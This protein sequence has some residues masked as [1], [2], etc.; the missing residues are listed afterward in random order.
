MKI[1]TEQDEKKVQMYNTLMGVKPEKT[2][3]KLNRGESKSPLGMLSK[4][5]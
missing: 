4:E 3:K 2:W 5:S 1:I